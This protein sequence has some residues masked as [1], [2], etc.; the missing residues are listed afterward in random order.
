[1]EVVMIKQMPHQ[2]PQ[3]LPTAITE[4]VALRFP[5]LSDKLL[6][7]AVEDG[8]FL[9]LCGD[10]ASLIRTLKTLGVEESAHRDDLTM[11]KGALELEILERLSRSNSPAGGRLGRA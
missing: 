11:L 3:A 7:K 8:D 6:T 5:H 1:V 4:A 9:S 10:Y 2:M